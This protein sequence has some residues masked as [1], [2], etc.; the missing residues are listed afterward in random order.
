MV[1]KTRTRSRLMAALLMSTA[2]SGMALVQ[3]AFAQSESRAYAAFA[4][5]GYNYC[6]AKL[7]GALWDMTPAQGKVAIGQKSLNGFGHLVG[8]VLNESRGVGNR[9]EWED[10]GLTY[11]DAQVMASVWG[12]QTPYQ[13]KLKAAMHYTNGNSDFVDNALG[14]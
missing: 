9:C 1:Q 12:L 14:R 10:T 5:S 8:G 3:P 7:L 2:L 13:A 6:D 11:Q 4:R